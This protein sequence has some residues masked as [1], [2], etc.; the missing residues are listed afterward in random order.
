M[1]LSIVWNHEIW[2]IGCVWRRLH[3]HVDGK[4]CIIICCAANCMLSYF[5]FHYIWCLEKHDT[6]NNI[7]SKLHLTTAKEQHG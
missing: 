6:S 5:A 4:K 1:Q 3:S 7:A 2:Y